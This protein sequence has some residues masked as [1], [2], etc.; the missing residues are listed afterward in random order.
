MRRFLL[1]AFLAL[2]LAA[3][4]AF[5]RA[6]MTPRVQTSSVPQGQTVRA[7][8]RTE[9]MMTILG[10]EDII[11]V[12]GCGAVGDSVTDDTAAVQAAETAAGA[13]GVVYFPSGTY[14]LC[15]SLACTARAYIG[16]GS[17]CVTLIQSAANTPIFADRDGVEN[18]LFEG[19]SVRATA[20]GVYGFS[21]S[22]V[23]QYWSKCT[24]R[25]IGFWQDLE[26]GISANVIYLHIENCE[27]GCLGTVRN[28]LWTALYVRGQMAGNAS[29]IN[30]VENTRFYGRATSATNSHALVDLQ[31]NLAN[32]EFH[33]CSFEATENCPVYAKGCYGLS[34]INCWFEPQMNDGAG[35]EHFVYAGSDGTQ[36]TRPVT[37]QHCWFWL[38]SSTDVKRIVSLGPASKA[39]F[40]DCHGNLNSQYY[41][42]DVAYDGSIEYLK[43]NQCLGYGGS[44]NQEMYL[45][46]STQI[47]GDLLPAVDNT[48]YLGHNDDSPAAWKGL[49]LKD[50]RNGK[51]YRIEVVNG[52][53]TATD[54]MD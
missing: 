36:G 6:R 22:D 3:S 47:A 18:K 29:N 48:Y 31:N 15:G 42:S 13:T 25:D 34:F 27:F 14:V 37:F 41:T 43:G 35:D 40:Q 50:T 46:N 16:A 21:C 5:A 53:V 26:R 32:W 52:V 7:A 2:S 45:G 30:R 49:I 44:L 12:R 1:V 54:L 8:A 10:R 11:N 23:S 38:P 9:G 4:F 28:D 20:D 51:Y 24:W 39:A 19:F 17:P 33:S